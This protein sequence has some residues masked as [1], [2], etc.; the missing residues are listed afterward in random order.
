MI[1]FLYIFTVLLMIM[2]GCARPG[3][4]EIQSPNGQ[5]KARITNTGGIITYQVFHKGQQIIEPSTLGVSTS[6]ADF[7]TGLSIDRLSE[8]ASVSEEY[9]TP[10]EKRYHNIYRANERS[11]SVTDGDGRKLEIV[12]RV[13]DDGVAFRYRFPQPDETGNL[14]IYR[15]YTTFNIPDGAKAWLHPHADVKT[16]WA[17]T[18]PSYEENYAIDI[19]A[20]TPSPQAAGWSFPALFQAGENWLLISE[21]GLEPPYC[22]TRLAQ[23]S[24]NGE[25]AIA[26]P[27]Q[28]ETPLPN[29]PLTPIG[30]PP[31][32]SN[33]RTI[34]A[35]SLATIT[36][37]NMVTALAAPVSIDNPGLFKPGIASWSWGMLKDQSVN[38]NTQ[39]EFI[40]HAA[41]MGWSY[42]L[43]DVNW[44]TQIGYEKIQELTGYAANLNIGIILWYNSSGEWNSTTYTPKSRLTD[45]EMR[46]AE[47]GRISRMGVKGVKVDFWPGDGP[48]AIRY[49]YDI[50][51]DAA[52]H[53]LM[54]NFHGTTVA[55]GWSRTFPNL[56]T[57]E[58]V[59]GFEF[60]TFEQQHNDAN[61]VH[62]TI[63][64]FTRN[65]IGHMD[66]TPV[67]FDEIP[68]IERRTTNGFELATSILFQSGIQHIVETPRSISRQPR[69][70]I[71]FLRELP[72]TWDDIK[73]LGGFPGKYV[74]LARQ[75]GEKWYVAG[76]NGQNE[77]VDLKIDL[78][79]LNPPP[80][81][82]IITDGE[83][84]RSFVKIPADLTSHTMS[85]T[86]RPRGGFVMVF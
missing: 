20:G 19:P 81:T 22:G 37:S 30:R 34:M 23:H 36:E 25:Y 17:E 82:E 29:D 60:T 75:S 61:P 35:G 59:K 33:W 9:E 73:L 83:N 39:K 80:T 31:F 50:M 15:E 49:Y 40:D 78:S 27:Q 11:I 77:A 24:P 74:V 57:M 16:G 62:C 26:F 46:N 12:F 70:V 67:N 18:Q 56:A 63:L 54:V 53:G 4:F 76:I 6:L 2:V 52:R 79:P 65:V 72:V 3:S 21:S 28:G 7:S 5:V 48:A 71:D 38:Y 51:A 58:S 47:F 42:C 43:I 8:V 85:M 32:C 10:T 84:D 86:I 66:Y 41:Q 13:S 69:Y 1:R 44:D 55:R 64:P 14:T 45:A 68:G